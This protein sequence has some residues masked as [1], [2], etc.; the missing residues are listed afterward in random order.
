[1]DEP[2]GVTCHNVRDKAGQWWIVWSAD[3]FPDKPG[4]KPHP[5]SMFLED[6]YKLGRRDV[7]GWVSSH[8]SSPHK[9]IVFIASPTWETQ[10]KE[11]G[12]E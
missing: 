12:I 7:V 10:L 6:A 4:R 1:M 5:E 3:F 9:A 8:N 11:W 2:I